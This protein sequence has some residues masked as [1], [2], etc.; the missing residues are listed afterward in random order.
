MI[1]SF[2][3]SDTEALANGYRIPR[4]VNI[5]RVAQRKLRQLKV[6]E[7]L[8]DLKSPPGNHLEPLKGD[9][10]GQLSIRINKVDPLVKTKNYRV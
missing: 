10:D 3:C 1:I 4:F 8:S 7:Q 6:S 5:E 9:R 2:K